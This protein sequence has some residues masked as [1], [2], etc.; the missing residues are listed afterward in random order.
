MKETGNNNDKEY[1][2]EIQNL[3]ISEQFDKNTTTKYLIRTN[4]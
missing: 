3:Q 2:S 4:F 1:G